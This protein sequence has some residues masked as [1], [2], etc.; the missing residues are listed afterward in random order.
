MIRAYQPSDETA[1]AAMLESEGI[2]REDMAFQKCPTWVMDEAGAKG[3][4]TVRVEHGLP[5]LVH[6]CI[7]RPSRVPSKARELITAFKKIIGRV[8]KKCLMNVPSDSQY[9]ERL[10]SRYFRCDPYAEKDNCKFFLV[11]V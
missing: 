6:F 7:A 5:Y 10:V 8:S 2:D 1:I 11:E 4:F 9:L 3:F